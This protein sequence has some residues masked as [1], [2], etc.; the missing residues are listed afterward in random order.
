M[1]WSLLFWLSTSLADNLCP[2]QF[3][4]LSDFQL[5]PL[6]LSLLLLLRLLL[7]L[8]LGGPRRSTTRDVLQVTVSRPTGEE[9]GGEARDRNLSTVKWL[10]GQ[11]EEKGSSESDVSNIKC[12]TDDENYGNFSS[13]QSLLRR[14]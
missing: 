14:S 11:E 9:G 1:W 2:S 3:K 12:P 8:L 4:K 6:I 7:L 5:D 13:A 10:A